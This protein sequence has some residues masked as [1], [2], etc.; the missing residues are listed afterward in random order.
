[1]KIYYVRYEN[2]NVLKV[3]LDDTVKRNGW[4][5]RFSKTL[6]QNGLA[7][8]LDEMLSG[9]EPALVRRPCHLAGLRLV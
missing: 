6:I 1:M 7:K 4:T 5:R 8:R 9:G 3:R 2:I